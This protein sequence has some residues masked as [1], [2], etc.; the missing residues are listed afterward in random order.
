MQLTGLRELYR[1]M[2]QQNIE[3]YRFHFSFNNVKFDVLYFIDEQPN[4]LIFGIVAYNYYFEIPVHKGFNIKPFINE[5]NKF[6]EIMG[7]KYNR[8]SPFKASHFFE[9]FNNNVPPKAIEKNKPKPQQIAQYRD[10]SEE[11]DKIYF[12]GWR[13][14]SKTNKKVTPENLEKTKKLLSKEAY[15]RCIKSNISSCWTAEQTKA[16]DFTLPYT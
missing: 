4:V 9:Q 1:S 11:P 15:N 6:C 14:N 8:N 13:D 5:F 3:R 16:K 7:F 10:F 12:V 2:K